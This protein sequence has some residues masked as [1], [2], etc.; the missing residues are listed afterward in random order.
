VSEHEQGHS[1][2]W[3]CGARP[4]PCR[5]RSSRGTRTRSW[6]ARACARRT[7]CFSRS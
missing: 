6:R 3:S 4:L 2:R 7:A 1:S 5:W